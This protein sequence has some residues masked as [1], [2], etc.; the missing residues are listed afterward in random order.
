ML[1]HRAIF[2]GE[3]PSRW[4]DA[5]EGLRGRIIV[6]AGIWIWIWVGIWVWIGIWIWGRIG[7]DR[8]VGARANDFA[9]DEIVVDV[10][11]RAF[12]RE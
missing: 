5:D 6:G 9:Y 8:I 7:N 11:E 2:G 10:V 3:E 1:I 12:G 4:R